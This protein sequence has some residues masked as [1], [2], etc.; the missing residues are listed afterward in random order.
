MISQGKTSHD[1]FTSRAES[2]STKTGAIK[3]TENV[4]KSYDTPQEAMIAWLNSPE[5]SNNIEGNYSLSAI[6]I[7]ANASGNLYFTQIFIQ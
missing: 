2:I 5:R 6:C 1:N 3:V 7:K 4:A